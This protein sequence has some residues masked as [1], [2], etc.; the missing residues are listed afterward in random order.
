MTKYT[1]ASLFDLDQTLLSENSSYSFGSYLYEKKVI[2]LASMLY[3]VG[4]YSLL[5]VGKLSLYGVHEK[6]FKTLFLGHSQDL[7]KQLA[8]DFVAD[9]LSRMLYLPA[10]HRLEES[11]RRG[12]FTAILSSSPSFL[13]G[14]I[15]KQFGI[16]EYKATEYETDQDGIFVSVG[17]VLDGEG[18]ASYLQGFYD[19]VHIEPI[20]VTAYT[21]SFL[22]MPLLIQVGTAVGVNPDNKLRAVCIKNGWEII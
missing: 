11:Q 12:H 14:L 15:A 22:D 18:K 16:H 1:E 4:C 6:I 19:R 21:D 7:L 2:S 5:K 3:C 17:K 10:I 20:N 13:V 8:A 9:N